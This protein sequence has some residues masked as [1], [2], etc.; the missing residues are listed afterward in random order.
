MELNRPQVDVGFFTNRINEMKAF[1]SDTLG[2]Q[3][4]FPIL[5]GLK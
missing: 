1:Y 2:L 4:Q 3:L 5:N